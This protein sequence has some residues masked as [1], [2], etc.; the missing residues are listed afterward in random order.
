MVRRTFLQRGKEKK[1]LIL[2]RDKEI[3]L[4]ME[5]ELSEM[6]RW[7]FLQRGKKKKRLILQR[8]KEINFIKRKREKERKEI[9]LRMNGEYRM[10][11]GSQESFVP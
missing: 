3:K 4:R 11:N 9:K 2:Q 8:E 1:R 10:K 6:V 5:N 7:T